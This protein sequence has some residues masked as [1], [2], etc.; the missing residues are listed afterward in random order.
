[1]AL[2]PMSRR[3]AEG[4]LIIVSP[5]DRPRR[6]WKRAAGAQT[7]ALPP[8]VAVGFEAALRRDPCAAATN[9]IGSDPGYAGKT[10]GS[11]PP[12][13]VCWLH[14]RRYGEGVRFAAEA[15][16]RRIGGCQHRLEQRGVA[17]DRR[18]R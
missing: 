15:V 1:M 17:A 14:V 6:S 5:S 3:D 9:G 12:D 7:L 4:C 11:P 2:P 18:D 10:N 8:L 16:A 13:T